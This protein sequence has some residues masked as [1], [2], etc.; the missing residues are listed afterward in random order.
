MSATSAAVTEPSI[1]FSMARWSISSPDG[2]MRSL[3]I[4][5]DP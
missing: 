3:L 5:S 1:S 4:V 2:T